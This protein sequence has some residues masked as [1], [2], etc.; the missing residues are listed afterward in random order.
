MDELA[1]NAVKDGTRVC[2]AVALVAASLLIAVL[3]P[4][5]WSCPPMG[6]CP[7]VPHDLNAFIW[8]TVLVLG[9]GA[10]VAVLAPLIRPSIH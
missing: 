6:F 5:R 7:V 3:L 1:L 2:I 8:V 4:V 9:I 10:A